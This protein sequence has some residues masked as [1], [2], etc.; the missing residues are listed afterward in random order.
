MIEK[1]RFCLTVTL[2]LVVKF[3]QAQDVEISD[4][5]YNK[6]VALYNEGREWLLSETNLEEAAGNFSQAILLNPYNSDYYLALS[7]TYGHLGKLGLALVNILKAIEL[8]PNQSDYH[9]EAATLYYKLKEYDKAVEHYSIAINSN[10]TSDMKIDLA[11][12]YFNR[13]SSS[14]YLKKYEQAINDFSKSIEL[15][16]EFAGAYHNRGVARLKL[17]NN[18]AACKD[19]EKAQD[20]G[21]NISYKYIDRYCDK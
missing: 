5:D 2:C 11:L 9:N 3:V 10:S 20:Y 13:G 18:E 12:A 6:G 19:F 21:S 14:M 15:D 4:T 1:F 16:A 17:K 7:Q 8:A